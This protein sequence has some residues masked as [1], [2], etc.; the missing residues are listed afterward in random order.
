VCEWGG[1]KRENG[2]RMST[3]PTPHPPTHPPT[4]IHP[5]THPPTHS[6]VTDLPDNAVARRHQ[7]RGVGVRRRQQEVGGEGVG[8]QGLAAVADDADPPGGVRGGRGVR[9]CGCV[10]AVVWLRLCGCGCDVM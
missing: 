5:P 10:V 9:G 1:E 6:P 3:T 7:V 8:A 2:A 4:R